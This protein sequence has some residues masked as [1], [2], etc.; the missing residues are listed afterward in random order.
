MSLRGDVDVK[1]TVAIL[2]L[3]GEEYLDELLRAC[4]AQRTTDPFEILVIDSGSVDA[5]SSIVRRHDSV[6]LVEI[7]NTEFGH[8]RTRNLANRL[9]EGEVVVF[10]TQDATPASTEWLEELLQPFSDPNVAGVFGR[11]IP[12][13]DCCPAVQRSLVETFDR[14]PA[15]F[16]SNVNSAIRSSALD[17][18]PF[19]DVEYAE[20]LAFARDAAA[21]GY[22]TVY[23]PRAAVWHSHNL[24]IAD[25]FRRMYDE[26][27]GVRSG[28]GRP[29]NRRIPWLLAVTI[30][31][32]I[33]DWAFIM[34]RGEYGPPAAVT[35]MMKAPIYNVARRLAIWLAWSDDVPRSVQARLSL[36][37]KRRRHARQ[38]VL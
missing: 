28:P 8:G 30:R 34:K 33:K 37:S 1:A 12:R 13:P 35:W 7:P 22:R 10:L 21:V 25:Y 5:T 4:R 14:P 2:T 18:V 26:A 3:N 11:Q 23:A 27:K 6:R 20:D 31:G 15:Q 17:K 9:S 36:D 24:R 16:F 38:A 32:T 19:Q 29:W